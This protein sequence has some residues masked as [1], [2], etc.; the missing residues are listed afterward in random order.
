MRYTGILIV[1]TLIGVV[2]LDLKMAFDM[3]NHGILIQKLIM[4]GIDRDVMW[5][6]SYLNNRMQRAKVNGSLSN[7]WKVQCGVPQG[8][9][10]GLLLFIIYIN[11]LTEFLAE[12]RAKLYA[13]NIA[14]YLSS[15]SYINLILGLQIEMETSFEWL[16]ANKLTLNL[17][18]TKFMMF[19]TR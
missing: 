12:A 1:V 16:K 14:V 9:I 3:V 6:S 17:N 8:C 5:F 11:D 15:P 2:F 18:K 10:L 7:E 19:G 4:Y 13:D